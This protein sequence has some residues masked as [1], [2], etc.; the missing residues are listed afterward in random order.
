MVCA[1][2]EEVKI[3]LCGWG[4]GD[5]EWLAGGHQLAQLWVADWVP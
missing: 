1:M 5:G 4:P 2:G 3:T